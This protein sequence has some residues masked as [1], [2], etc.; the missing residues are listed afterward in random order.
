M[1]SKFYYVLVLV[2]PLILSGCNNLGA[3]WNMGW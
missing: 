2:L 1:N 3:A